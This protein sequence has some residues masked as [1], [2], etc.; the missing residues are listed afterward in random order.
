MSVH[1]CYPSNDTSLFFLYCSQFLANFVF[2]ILLIPQI[3]IHISCNFRKWTVL[4]LHHVVIFSHLPATLDGAMRTENF[5]F[6]KQFHTRSIYNNLFIIVLCTW[7]PL[8]FAV[9]NWSTFP[10]NITQRT[11]CDHL[12]IPAFASIILSVG[13]C[14]I[15]AFLNVYTLG[16]IKSK[17]KNHGNPVIKRLRG[18]K[19]IV[20]KRFY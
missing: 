11:V 8:L 12:G 5:P 20:G 18:V 10:Q 14:C 4:W 3:S 13:S 16:L 17:N 6:Y 1:R 9:A 15:T 19:N 7:V 2:S